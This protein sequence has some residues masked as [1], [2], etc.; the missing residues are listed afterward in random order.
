MLKKT[1]ERGFVVIIAIIVVI[2][3]VALIIVITNSGDDATEPVTEPVAGQPEQPPAEPVT[4]PDEQQPETGGE[5]SV[6]TETTPVPAPETGQLPADWDQLS[7]AEKIALN[8][9]GCDVT[10]Q[11]IWAS[12]GSCHDK[13]GVTPDPE[14]GELFP[15]QYVD[16][17]MELV[18]EYDYYQNHQARPYCSVQ[19]KVVLLTTIDIENIYSETKKMR[20]D[21]DYRPSPSPIPSFLSS[22][23]GQNFAEEQCLKLKNT[24][25]V[26][27]VGTHGPTRLGCRDSGLPA[28]MKQGDEASVRVSAGMHD[29]MS[30]SLKT[31]P[32]VVVRNLMIKTVRH[33]PVNVSTPYVV[34]RESFTN[35]C[36]NYDREKGGI[37]GAHASVAIKEAPIESEMKAIATKFVEK[38]GPGEDVRLTVLRHNGSD[39]IDDY[40]V[41]GLGWGPIFNDNHQCGL[42]RLNTGGSGSDWIPGSSLDKCQSA[43]SIPERYFA[44]PQVGSND[45]QSKQSPFRYIDGSFKASCDPGEASFCR[46]ELEVTLLE[47]IDT[48]RRLENR[49]TLPN[50]ITPGDYIDGEWID[51]PCLGISTSFFDLSSTSIRSSQISFA[52]YDDGQ[53]PDTIKAGGRYTIKSPTAGAITDGSSITLKTRPEVTITNIEVERSR[54]Q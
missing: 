47:D 42:Y 49:F 16:N 3:A 9:L 21:R 11:I 25:A 29:D 27:S 31:N 15:F 6:P 19:F 51:G 13:E 30:V 26:P 36:I 38:Y 32:E 23:A 18:C 28:V 5:Q 20:E 54:G 46:V 34:L 10:T 17:S 52:C 48:R 14:T 7:S 41:Y 35:S 4:E 1:N 53:I 2:I 8:P 33:Q 39:N 40:Y 24:F 45:W 43:R 37:C 12:D 22:V 50:F 44:T